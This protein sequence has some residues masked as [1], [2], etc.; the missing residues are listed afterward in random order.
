MAIVQPPAD[1]AS[2]AAKCGCPRLTCIPGFS[3]LAAS[4]LHQKTPPA[5]CLRS[6]LRG[7]ARRGVRPLEP[8]PN[9]AGGSCS[10]NTQSFSPEGARMKRIL[11]VSPRGGRGCRGGSAP[12]SAAL[13]RWARAFCVIVDGENP[14]T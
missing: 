2:S 9:P 12:D 4:S 14:S 11:S 3:L 5:P 1:S 7:D 10:P 13:A 8:N 6:R